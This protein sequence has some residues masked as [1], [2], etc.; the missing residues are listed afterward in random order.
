MAQDED[1][2]YVHNPNFLK[3]TNDLLL[4]LSTVTMRQIVSEMTFFCVTQAQ[5]FSTG[6]PRRARVPSNSS[7]C[8]AKSHN[9]G[10]CVQKMWFFCHFG[11]FIPLWCAVKLFFTKLVCRKLKKVENHCSSILFSN[12][13]LIKDMA[14]QKLCSQCNYCQTRHSAWKRIVKQNVAMQPFAMI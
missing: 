8:S 13:F 1:K 9:I 11:S 6:V 2:L 14:C 3:Q 4:S 10:D 5:C 7:K 12:S